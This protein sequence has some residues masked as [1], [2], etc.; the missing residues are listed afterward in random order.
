M[1]GAHRENVV[2][3]L[4]GH[5][6]IEIVTG[7]KT[8]REQND[9]ALQRAENE[10]WPTPIAVTSCVSNGSSIRALRPTRH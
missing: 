8:S 2:R 6:V 4:N 5:R 3:K 9:F 1:S 7:R 10:G